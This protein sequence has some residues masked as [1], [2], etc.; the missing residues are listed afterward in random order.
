MGDPDFHSRLSEEKR[1]G[2][3]HEL[4]EGRHSNV[5]DLALKAAEQAIEA[6]AAKDGLHFHTDPRTAHASRRQWLHDH[7]PD[8]LVQL[9]LL[10]GAYGDLG[11]DGLDGDRAREAVE[12]MEAILRGLKG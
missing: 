7:H 2:A 9:D 8:L 11:Y 4:K 5:G 10:W 3:L 1:Q 12:A 6:V